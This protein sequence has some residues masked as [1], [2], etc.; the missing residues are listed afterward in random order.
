MTT[1]VLPTLTK[2]F[3]LPWTKSSATRNNFFTETDFF[4]VGPDYLEKSWQHCIPF[5]TTTFVSK[6]MKEFGGD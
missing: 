3:L 6:I 4:P 1:A 5:Y 2:I